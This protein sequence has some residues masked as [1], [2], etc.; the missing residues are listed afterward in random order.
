MVI[1]D[2][3]VQQLYLKKT[4]KGVYTFFGAPTVS[5]PEIKI[6]ENVKPKDI[7][8]RI[9][10][11]NNNGDSYIIDI[12][13]CLYNPF[14]S[15]EEIRKNSI[16]FLMYLE[17]NNFYY[18]YNDKT[19]AI[20]YNTDEVKRIFIP[21]TFTAFYMPKKIITINE[22]NIE[23]RV[24][25]LEKIS[26]NTICS[27][28]YDVTFDVSQKAEEYEEEKPKVKILKEPKVRR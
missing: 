20:E 12:D 21:N 7:L 10:K 14:A 22:D 3:F 9:C 11:Q 23:T 2:K 1:R 6:E 4:D 24:V 17:K 26:D 8:R 15:E 28:V 16:D 13:G 5:E 27:K 18:K 19:G 25:K